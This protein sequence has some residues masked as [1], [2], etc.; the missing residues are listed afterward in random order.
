M[1]DLLILDYDHHEVRLLVA[2]EGGGRL[3]GGQV[4]A[5]PLEGDPTPDTIAAAAKSLLEAAGSRGKVI[6]LVGGREVQSRLVRV[7]PVP[8]DELPEIVRLRAAT[9]L[10]PAEGATVIDFLPLE[11]SAGGSALVLAA[12]V[13]EKTLAH[14]RAI[15][16]KLHLTPQHVCLRGCGIAAVAARQ[17]AELGSGIHLVAAVRGNSLD[18]VGIDQGLP[19]VMRTV[20]LPAEGAGASRAAAA[21]REIR[22]TMAAVSSELAA[23]EVQSLA[24]LCG[25]THDEALAQ[26]LAEQ[27]AC[28]VHPIDLRPLVSSTSGQLSAFAGM[29]GCGQALAAQDTAIDFL[30]PRRPPEKQAPVRTY[31]MAAGLAALVILGL[32]YLA[33]NSVASIERQAEA[34]VA[35]R[36]DIESQLEQL[37]PDRQQAEAIEA[38]LATDVNWLDELD[39][40][41]LTLRPEPLDNH[42]QFKPQRDVILTSLAAKQAPGR[43][44]VGGTLELAGGV[45]DDDVL[46]DLE[47]QLRD[48][49]RQVNPKLMLKDPE[50][51]PYVWSFQDD[52]VVQPSGEGWP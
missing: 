24:W 23:T 35:D 19:A 48:E 13:N 51:S 29:L 36:L 16:A 47:D 39:H 37:D 41:A 21:A 34:H 22:R 15:A 26:A 7:P 43:N 5:A 52:L 45:R 3:Q 1:S 11:T 40:V 30:A 31:A 20:G 50:A 10:P 33:Y 46:E 42:E 38:W 17:Q 8:A 32:G 49:R 4:S 14:A 27:L 9:E 25:N 12:R 6:V 2:G 44:A 28:P 18:L